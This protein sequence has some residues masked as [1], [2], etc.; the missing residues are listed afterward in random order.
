MVLIGSKQRSGEKFT[1]IACC[2]LYPGDIDVIVESNQLSFKRVLVGLGRDDRKEFI[3]A[4]VEKS[5]EQ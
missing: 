2:P 3:A 5:T 1:V 4:E